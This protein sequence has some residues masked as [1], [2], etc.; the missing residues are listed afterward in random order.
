MDQLGKAHRGLHAL[1]PNCGL[2]VLN[3]LGENNGY[4]NFE[5]WYDQFNYALRANERAQ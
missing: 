2:F 5:N 1:L 3:G 4:Y